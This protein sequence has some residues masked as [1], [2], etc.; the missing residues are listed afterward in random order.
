M[1]LNENKHNVKNVCR[2]ICKFGLLKN[3]ECND[4]SA[5]STETIQDNTTENQITTTQGY[6]TE[7]CINRYLYID[8][9]VIFV[10]S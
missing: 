5:A 2:L 3:D 4:I 9:K 10:A 8:T 7:Y 1:N 6:T